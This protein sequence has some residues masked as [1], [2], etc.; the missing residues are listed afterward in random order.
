MTTRVS[1]RELVRGA[2]LGLAAAPS[3]LAACT[4][5]APPPA[6][7]AP[8][9]APP[10]APAGAAPTLTPRVALSGTDRLVKTSSLGISAEAP[11][12]IAAEKGY[13]RDE[14][15]EIELIP[16]LPGIQSIPALG[17][18]DLDVS[19]GAIGPALFRALE[20]G[21]DVKVIGPVSYMTE[22]HG[23]VWLSRRTDLQDQ[24][25]SLRDLQGTKLAFV[26]HGGVNDYAFGRAFAREGLDAMQAV[27][28]VTIEFGAMPAALA[29]KA[30]ETALITEPMI[31]NT[32]ELGLGDRWLSMAQ[33]AGRPVLV[34]SLLAGPA[35]LAKGGGETVVRWLKAYMRGAEQYHRAF[36]LNDDPALRRELV[37]LLI[38]TTNLKD[39][40]IYDR[41]GYAVIPPDGALDEGSIRDQFAFWESQGVAVP[42]YE[43]MV[44]PRPGRAAAAALGRP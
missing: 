1:R 10:V 23:T 27:D 34:T 36:V 5:A 16:G 24:F 18:G 33:L 14:G 2:L 32:V 29:N 41:I 38:K 22:T 20:R 39:P 35:F 19:P 11:I 21:V 8:T 44:D 6:P 25:R 28:Y 17:T 31:T 9:A 37:A 43:T 13:F 12:H 26:G 30:V 4:A 15:L 7:V 42:A 3:V 40:A